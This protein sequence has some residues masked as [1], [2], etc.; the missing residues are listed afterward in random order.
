MFERF[1]VIPAIDLKSGQVVRLRQ[2]DMGV[3]T[4]YGGDPAIVARSFAAQGA[5]LIHIVDLDGAIAG[6]PCNLDALRRIRA[7]TD[8]QIEVSGGLR[9]IEAVRQ[10]AAAGAD[11]ISIGS[12][13]VLDPELLTQACAELPGRVFGS[14]DVREGRLAIKGWLQTSQLAIDEAITRFQQAGV[15]ALIVTDISR[16]GT[17]QGSHVA[18]FCEIAAISS[19]PVV[20]SG[21]VA[22]LDDIRA[23]KRQFARGIAGVIAGRALYEQR[24]T[25]HEALSAAK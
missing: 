16:D 14:L 11:F 6:A 21:G 10:V 20:A 1:T 12:A 4:V 17:E 2:G 19:L 3:P 15:A 18:L 22:N 5:S 23:L 8:C 13:A 7:A 9:T 24:F 25:L